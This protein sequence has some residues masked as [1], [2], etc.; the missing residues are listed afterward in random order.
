MEFKNFDELILKVQNVQ[1]KKKVVV[2]STQDE[3]TL[4]AVFRAKNDN[5]VEPILLGNKVKIKEILAHLC[6]EIEDNAIIDVEEDSSAAS[7]AVEL[8]NV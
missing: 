4:E 8:I 6:V 1:S 5:I 2:V 3:H 7:K